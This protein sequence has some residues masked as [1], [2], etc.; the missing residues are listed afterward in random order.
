[1]YLSIDLCIFPL[2][3]KDYR[4]Q[5]VRFKYS[6]GPIFVKFFLIM[7]GLNLKGFY[8]FGAEGNKQA[9]VEDGCGDQPY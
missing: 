8:P 9:P 6:P 1:M 3:L 2:W 7:E 4:V 5:E